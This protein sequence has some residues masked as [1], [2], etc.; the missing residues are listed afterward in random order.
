MAYP[1]NKSELKESGKVA[2]NTPTILAML[3]NANSNPKMNSPQLGKNLVRPAYPSVAKTVPIS[4]EKNIANVG[5]T[6][7]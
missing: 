4:D 6:S 5:T 2:P 7:E 1:R 3:K